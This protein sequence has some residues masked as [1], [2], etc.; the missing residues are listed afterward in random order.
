MTSYLHF[1]ALD[2]LHTALL[3]PLLP[4]TSP[5]PANNVNG[6]KFHVNI[7]QPNHCLAIEQLKHAR[8]EGGKCIPFP[9]QEDPSLWCSKICCNQIS[10]S[11]LYRQVV[12]LALVGTDLG[13]RV[14]LNRESP[15]LRLPLEI[16]CRILRFAVGDN[17]FHIRYV[18]D[19]FESAENKW[20]T[21]TCVKSHRSQLLALLP[22]KSLRGDPLLFAALAAIM[23]IKHDQFM[24]AG[25]SL[26]EIDFHDGII[27][28]CVGLSEHPGW[29]HP[30]SRLA[31]KPGPVRVLCRPQLQFLRTCRQIYMEACPILWSCNTFAFH[32]PESFDAFMAHLN[33]GQK[34]LI[35]NI[36]LAVSC[37]QIWN[38]ALKVST[39]R[40]LTG[41]SSLQMQIDHRLLR[42]LRRDDVIG[43][44]RLCNVRSIANFEVLPLR[45]VTIRIKNLA[46]LE[47]GGYF[48]ENP[49]YERDF[50]V[51]ARQWCRELEARIRDPEGLL[52]W[53]EEQDK[54]QL[55][56]RQQ[57]S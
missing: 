8:E 7:A 26:D 30:L 44:S 4:L 16:Q 18:L 14:Q 36:H 56:R 51:R 52:R 50:P 35:T 21:A 46:G 20:R 41:L 11:H 25:C 22:A 34:S 31:I 54:R 28:F 2:A 55:S 15:L 42:L 40:C 13:P 33:A 1:L 27:G 38:S 49:F 39:I 29:G 57:K 12:V 37:W 10:V 48:D 5:C 32:N 3:L 19:R 53:R 45:N 23:T 47:S 43:I 17:V 6:L 9:P 24:I